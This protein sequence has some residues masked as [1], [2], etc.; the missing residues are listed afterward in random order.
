MLSEREP[1]W[2][3]IEGAE[4]EGMETEE[5]AVSMPERL[6]LQVSA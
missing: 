6:E 2:N 1:R 5:N 4:R 3:D